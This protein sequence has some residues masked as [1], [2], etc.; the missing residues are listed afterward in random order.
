MKPNKKDQFSHL[1]MFG[2]RTVFFIL[3]YNS[4][5]EGSNPAMVFSCKKLQTNSAHLVKSN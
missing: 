3:F 4:Q 2:L 5:M 1:L